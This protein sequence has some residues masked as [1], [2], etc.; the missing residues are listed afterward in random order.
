MAHFV[1]VTVVSAESVRKKQLSAHLAARLVMMSGISTEDVQEVVCSTF[2][3]A[4]MCWKECSAGNLQSQEASY[5]IVYPVSLRYFR[6]DYGKISMLWLA[7]KIKQPAG[8]EERYV[9]HKRTE[10][11]IR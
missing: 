9:I 11:R 6:M 3:C 8:K 2:Y 5:C 7:F 4:G 10:S 1:N